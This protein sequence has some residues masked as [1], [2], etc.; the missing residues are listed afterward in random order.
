MSTSEDWTAGRAFVESAYTTA[1]GLMW[2]DTGHRMRKGTAGMP[3]EQTIICFVD[4]DGR[5]IEIDHLGVAHPESRGEFAIYHGEDQIGD[6]MLP[7]AVERTDFKAHRE[8]PDDAELIAQA[9]LAL[10]DDPRVLTQS[11]FDQALVK[12]L[13]VSS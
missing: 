10:V 6:F 1:Y 4:D 2:M 9:K 5:T 11:G 3:S 12:A 8:L 13:A 7:W